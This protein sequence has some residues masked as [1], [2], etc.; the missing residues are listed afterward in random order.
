MPAPVE[1]ASP[2]RGA[3][4]AVISSTPDGAGSLD[5][6]RCCRA[7]LLPSCTQRRTDVLPQKEPFARHP[8]RPPPA[9]AATRDPRPPELRRRFPGAVERHRVWL[10]R[11]PLRGLMARR[12]C[13]PSSRSSWRRRPVSTADVESALCAARIDALPTPWGCPVARG[14]IRLCL[15]AL[16]ANPAAGSARHEDLPHPAGCVLFRHRRPATT[17]RPEGRCPVGRLQR[18]RHL[19]GFPDLEAGGFKIAHE[20][21][22]SRFDPTGEIGRLRWQ[23]GC[24]RAISTAAFRKLAGRPWLSPACA[25]TRTVSNELPHRS[26]PVA[27]T[28]SWSGWLGHVFKHG[29]AAGLR[30]RPLYKE[31][32]GG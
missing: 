31:S 25:S 20:R 12:A 1:G 10:F 6:W 16:A 18:G 13:R 7:V 11:P 24:V 30:G 27:T 8:S 14:R 32:C 5:D 9:G 2:M 29:P 17:V 4:T 15:R 28:Q 3:A 22:G 23:A 26:P 21:H 19:Y